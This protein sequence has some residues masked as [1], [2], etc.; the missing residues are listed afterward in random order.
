MMTSVTASPI[1]NSTPISLAI[2]PILSVTLPSPPIGWKI[3][4]SYSKNARIVNKLGQ[5]NGDIPKYFVWNDIASINL[6]SSKIFIKS[7]ATDLCGLRTPATL[8]ALFDSKSVAPNHGSCRHCLDL[9]NFI[10][11]SS[12]YFLNP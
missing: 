12:R 1:L 6:S 8:I 9:S 4:Y 10:L 5:L 11:L 3:P 7:L 2:S